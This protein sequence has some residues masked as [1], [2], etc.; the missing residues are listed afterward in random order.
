MQDGT[1]IHLFVDNNVALGTLLRGS[2]RQHDWNEL[3]ADIWFQTAARGFVLMCWRVPSK[4]NLA[5][6]PTRPELRHEELKQLRA[7]GFRQTMWRW[8]QSCP[9]TR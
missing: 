7:A 2:S 8:P 3:V 5:D 4:Q 6:A 9:W 1:E